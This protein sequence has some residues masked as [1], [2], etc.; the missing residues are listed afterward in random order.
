MNDGGQRLVTYSYAPPNPTTGAPHA[1]LTEERRARLS[2]EFDMG[3]TLSFHAGDIHDYVA[4]DVT[5]AYTYPWSGLGDNPSRRVEEW[6]RQ[7]V[8]IKPDLVIVFDRVE[9][10]DAMFP[11]T[12]MLHTE[13]KPT[14]WSRGKKVSPS[15]RPREYC[16]NPLRSPPSPPLAA[17]P[18]YRH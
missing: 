4:A 1:V 2:D 6:V 17:S 9:A 10:S 8:F 3:R 5:R 11:K 18:E 13:G 16:S 14:F 15:G 7:I 12:W